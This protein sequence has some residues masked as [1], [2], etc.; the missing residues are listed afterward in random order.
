MTLPDWLEPTPDAA[1]QRA[2]DEWAI[3]ERGIPGVEL[4]ERAGAGLARLVEE[5]APAGRVVVVCGKGNNG[6]DGLVVARVLRS[7]GREVSVLLTGAA[8]DFRGDALTNLERLPGP[9]PESFSEAALGRPAAI[10][11]AIL[12]TGF[13]GEP[14]D[15]AAGAIEAI[16]AGVGRD[17]LCLRRAQRRR[18]I[19]GRGLRDRSD[20]GGDGD[21]SC[22]QAR[23]VDRA[24]QSHA[25]DVVVV[26]I[27]IPDGGPS[28]PSIGLIDDAVVRAI[29]RRGR[30]STKFAA[31][32]VL[33]CGGS[34]GLT[35][36]PSMASEAA[37][38]AGAGYV[39]A[40]VPASLNLIFEVRLLEVMTV[41]IPDR[42][43]RFDAGG[44][45]Q[46]L[47]RTERVDSLVLGPG[48]GR[49]PDTLSFAR[50]VAGAA[51]VPLV[52]DADG[53]NAH[54]GQLEAVARRQAPTVLTPHAGELARLLGTDSP[55]GGRP[56]PGSRPPS[57]LL[58]R[59]GRSA[60]GRRHARRRARRTGRP[61]AE[62]GPRRSPRPE[63]AMS[64]PA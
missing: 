26:N 29:P 48:L 16:N 33:V 30:E 61:S 37:M 2:L 12:G 13:A 15:P 9:A 25:G 14:R 3:G 24:G 23:A 64:S 51:G 34:I 35:G 27:G 17:R 47:E 39:T 1:E 59:G 44:A 18:C 10:V 20:R 4:M 21:V 62:E 36:A 42:E 6:G 60:Q 22:K 45:A 54:A 38:R 46:V 28:H 31:G 8:D 5:R 43:G 11:D 58:R 56:P 63:P 49:D 40:C 57:R 52:L 32:S 50:A 55:V 7:Q 41:P 53:L 19:H